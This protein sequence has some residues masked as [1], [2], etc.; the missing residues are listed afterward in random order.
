MIELQPDLE[1]DFNCPDCGSELSSVGWYMPGMRTLADLECKECE[2]EYFGDLPISQGLVTPC[3]LEKDSG[4]I[5]NPYGGDWF[6]DWLK[7]SYQ[8]RSRDPLLIEK[9]Y[10]AEITN[11]IILN[12]L[13]RLYGHS[14]LK[15]LNSQHYID[16]RTEFDLIVLIPSQMDWLVPKGVTGTWSIEM[17]IT[18]GNQWNEWIAEEIAAFANEFKKVWAGVAFPH[19]H[20]K[21]YTISRFTG[22]E[23]FNYDQWSRESPKITYI[24]REDRCWI[25][26]IPSSPS[27]YRIKSKIYDKIS[28]FGVN[29]DRYSQHKLINKLDSNLKNNFD[30]LDLSVVGI[31]EPG[32]LP[33]HIGDYRL[34]APTAAEEKTMCE[35]YS[36]SEV[37]IGIHGSNMI[38]PSAHAGS[39]VEIMPPDRWTNITQDLVFD[40]K[41]ESREIVY[42]YR[43]IP[44]TTN[45]SEISNIILSMIKH[46]PF[47]KLNSK[48][49]WVNHQNINYEKHKYRY[50]DRK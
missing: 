18:S 49:K 3:L 9:E 43:H 21:D 39:V 46:R 13:D 50:P 29:L 32:G 30:N 31:G 15:L 16:Q 42:D 33:E 34:S 47:H 17:P 5:H 25:H 6:A 40:D 8:N 19:P 24:W 20:P 45:V 27:W 4:K 11:P 2:R 7:A 22:V 44:S 28:D 41:K 10:K 12:C 48:R 23:R 14:V 36:N 38:L 37:V 26:T 1:T 35:I